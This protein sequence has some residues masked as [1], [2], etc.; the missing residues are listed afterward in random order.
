MK[1]AREK[2]DKIEKE[3][4]RVLNL[5][6]HEN[7]RATRPL[8]EG[9]RNKETFATS[10]KTGIVGRVADMEKII[11]V[12]LRSEANEDIS[13]VPI[14]GLGGIGKSTLAE[15]V[16]ADIRVNVFSVQV[17][18]HVSEQFDLHK[19]GSAIIKSINSNINLDNCTLQFLLDNLKKEL[20]TLRYL[21][22]LDDL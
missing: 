21:I 6:G 20:A 16:L 10:M 3:G 7:Q 5:V 1:S 17:W 12:L 11:S 9:S 19:I 2:I 13:V 4:H 8:A 18:V 15:S 14:V 22:V